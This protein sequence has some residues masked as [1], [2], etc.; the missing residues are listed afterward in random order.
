MIGSSEPSTRGRSQE[1]QEF[2]GVSGYPMRS[3]HT[4]PGL[5]TKAKDRRREK[6]KSPKIYISNLF[7]KTNPSVA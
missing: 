5:K 2:K 3:R 4:E 6:G 7:F 1:D